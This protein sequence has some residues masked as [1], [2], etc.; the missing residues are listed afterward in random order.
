MRETPCARLQEANEGVFSLTGCELLSKVV[1]SLTFEG[2]AVST[3]H[4]ARS[5][6]HSCYGHIHRLAGTRSSAKIQR[7]SL[8]CENADFSA[9]RTSVTVVLS[10]CRPCS[11][12]S[13]GRPLSRVLSHLLKQTLIPF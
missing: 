13:F 12:N 11:G 2:L 7:V 8:D 10:T 6:L 4:L 3:D 9:S 5:M 1:T